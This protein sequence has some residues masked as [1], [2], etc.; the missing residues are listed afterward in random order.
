[1]G[2]LDT[3]VRR[4]RLASSLGGKG[5]ARGLAAGRLA[6]SL[7]GPGSAEAHGVDG[8]GLMDNRSIKAN[9]T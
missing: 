6:S 1:M 2:L 3:A 5:L 4:S 9:Q 8:S 7:L